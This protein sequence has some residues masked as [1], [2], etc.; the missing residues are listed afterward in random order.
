PTPLLSFATPAAL[1]TTMGSSVN[2]A[3]SS[4]LSGGSYGAITYSSASP[5]VATVN[6]SGV[7]TPVSAGTSAIT[8]SQAAVTGINA[9]ATQTYT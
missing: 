2:N 3:A 9:A 7:I 1:S 4:T 8:A 5:A 6:A